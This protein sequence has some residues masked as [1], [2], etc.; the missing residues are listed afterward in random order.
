MKSN[1]TKMLRGLPG[2]ALGLALTA[3]LVSA[4]QPSPSPKAASDAKSLSSAPAQV[5][6]DAGDYTIISS[7]EFGYRGLRVGGNVNKY[8]SDLNYRPGP[9]IF[10]SSFLMRAKEGKTGGFV[11]ELLVTSTGWGGDPYGNVRI[12]AE[13]SKWFRFDGTYRQFKY[14]SYL[15]N[16][17][18][19]NFAPPAR[20]S[21]P[22]AGW[23]NYNTRQKFGD[24]DL[25]ILPKNERIRFTIGYSP[26][27]YSGLS[28]TSYH[29]GGDDFVFPVNVTSRANNFR[30]GAD[31]KLGPIDFSFLQG[32]RRFRDD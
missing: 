32:F 12:S 18:N 11:D 6:E 31:G 4:Q 17:A 22:V 2:L 5:G 28:F 9:R 26:E 24:F 16:I 19:P 25:T 14:F 23:H 21:D 8:Q 30:L 27:R 29:V 7:I 20:Q 13:N 10:D 3:I 15:N 1:I